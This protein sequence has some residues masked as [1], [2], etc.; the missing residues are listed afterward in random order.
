MKPVNVGM[1]GEKFHGSVIMKWL[2]VSGI[3]VGVSLSA[4]L[5]VS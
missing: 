3:I 1:I 5:C 4:Q 2:W